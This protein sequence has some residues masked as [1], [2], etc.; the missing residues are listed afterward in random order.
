MFYADYHHSGETGTRNKAKESGET[1]RSIRIYGDLLTFCSTNSLR[2]YLMTY[3]YI[4]A[5]LIS[6]IY[7]MVR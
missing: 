5:L 1:A 6:Y 4:N 7:I 2:E 3:E